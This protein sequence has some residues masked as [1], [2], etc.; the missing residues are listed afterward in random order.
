VTANVVCPP[1]TDT[2]WITPDVERTVQESSEL[3][4][5]AQPEEVADVIAFLVSHEARLLTGNVVRLR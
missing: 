5:I 4:H 3:F 1:V 2:G